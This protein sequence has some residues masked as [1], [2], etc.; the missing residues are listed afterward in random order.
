M[1]SPTHMSLVVRVKEMA[2]SIYRRFR[3]SCKIQTVDRE[4]KTVHKPVTTN[5]HFTV[6]GSLSTIWILQEAQKLDE[7]VKVFTPNGQFNHTISTDARILVTFP[8]RITIDSM[9]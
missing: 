5:M 9:N 2:S 6:Y 4:P 8:T 7:C 1:T 3:A